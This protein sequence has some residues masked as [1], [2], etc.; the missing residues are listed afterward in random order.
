MLQA[1]LKPPTQPKLPTTPALAAPEQ[2]RAIAQEQETLTGP[3]QMDFPRQAEHT[4]PSL[5]M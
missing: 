4:Y 3:A 2:K 1:R 5:A